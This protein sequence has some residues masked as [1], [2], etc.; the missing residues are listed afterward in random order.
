[1]F[2][3]E[4]SD[5][6]ETDKKLDGPTELT[7]SST[8]QSSTPAEVTAKAGVDADDQ[9]EQG[10]D[11]DPESEA[12]AVEDAQEEKVSVQEEKSVITD[13]RTDVCTQEDS[14]SAC[15]SVKNEHYASSTGNV[16]VSET[17]SAVDNHPVPSGKNAAEPTGQ[18]VTDL[19]NDMERNTDAV[20][21]KQSKENMQEQGTDKTTVV[22]KQNSTLRGSR[23]CTDDG[24][25][26]QLLSSFSQYYETLSAVDCTTTSLGDCSKPMLDTDRWSLLPGVEDIASR[27]D[28]E[29]GLLKDSMRVDMGI[30]AGKKLWQQ[31]NNQVSS[32]KQKHECVELPEGC[33]IS[34]S[35]TEKSAGVHFNPS[36]VERK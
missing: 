34:L 6:D 16:T 29:D 8:S 4:A 14:E 2:D 1:L 30:Y 22:P 5:D 13:A 27:E 26:A 21:Q 23:K 10:D 32:W 20:D 35:E 25:G 7:V 17:A 24:L 15:L 19:E 31:V 12:V 9:K 36:A 11:S 28:L 33:S 18:V 3:S